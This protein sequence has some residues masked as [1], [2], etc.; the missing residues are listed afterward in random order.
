MKPFLKT[1]PTEKA[2]F[3]KSRGEDFIPLA[4]QYAQEADPN[5]ELYYNDYNEWY[6]EKVKNSH[7][8]G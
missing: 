8:N 1:E 7:C 3:T 6:P 2:N 4:F 5:A